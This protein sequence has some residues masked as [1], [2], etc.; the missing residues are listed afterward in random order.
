MARNLEVR[1]E[2]CA[3]L[4]QQLSRIEGQPV[5]ILKLNQLIRECDAS[6]K[7]HAPVEPTKIKPLRQRYHSLLKQLTSLRKRAMAENT[8]RKQHCLA[9]LTE[10]AQQEDLEAG[11]R[12]VAQS[13]I[14]MEANRTGGIC[15]GKNF[16]RG[17]CRRA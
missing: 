9:Q 5:H 14:G 3:K 10:L 17:L 12:A 13:A 6:W 15:R 16:A 4:E 7:Q 8:Q 1:T 11:R 2:L